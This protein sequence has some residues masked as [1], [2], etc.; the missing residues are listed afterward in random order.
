MARGQGLGAMGAVEGKIGLNRPESAIRAKLKRGMSLWVQFLAFILC[1]KYCGQ[2]YI[3]ACVMVT[4]LFPDGVFWGSWLVLGN[5]LL[6]CF[7]I[8]IITLVV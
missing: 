6:M 2:V 1:S 5:G 3:A 4:E 8:L 7:R